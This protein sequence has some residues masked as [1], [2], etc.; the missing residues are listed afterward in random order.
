M[1][2]G[3]IDAL[4]ASADG[5]G[6]HAAKTP[7][8][9]LGASDLRKAYGIQ[10]ASY[11]MGAGNTIAIIDLEDDPKAE[12]DMNAYR[13]QFG[14]PSCTSSSGCFTKVEENNGVGISNLKTTSDASET[15]ADLDMVSAACPA[16][17]IVLVE[18]P[19]A[20]NSASDARQLV[21]AFNYA[22]T[23]S[24]LAISSSVFASEF[25]GEVAFDAQLPGGVPI[26]EA[27]GDFPKL[28]YWPS[29]S[30]NQNVITV[31]GTALSASRGGVATSSTWSSTSAGCSK[32]EPSTSWLSI[33]QCHGKRAFSDVSA[34]AQNIAIYDT[35]RTKS[36]AN[37]FAAAG[38]S[39]AAPLIAGITGLTG[40]QPSASD[41]AANASKL[42]D[43]TTGSNA[44]RCSTL[45]CK[46]V[47]GWDAPTG[48]G[49]PVGLT[50]LL[51]GG[52]IADG[53]IA[54]GVNVDG[55]LTIG[56]SWASSEDV[57]NGTSLGLRYLPTNGD[58]ISPG[59]ACEGWG[60]ADGTTGIDGYADQATGDLNLNLDSFT[61]SA[62]SAT[63]VT[64]ISGAIRVTNA[65]G[66]TSA[67]SNAIVDR[68]TITNLQSDPIGDLLYERVAD[69]DME[70][71]AYNELVT[72]SGLGSSPSLVGLT[73]DG[74]QAPDPLASLTDLGA[75]SN[76]AQYGPL[77]QGVAVRFDFGSLDPGKSVTFNVYYGAASNEASA[78]KALTAVGAQV[79][80]LGEPSSSSDGSP[81]TAFLGFSGVGGAVMPQ[82]TTSSVRRFPS[83][84]Q[85]EQ[86]QL[87][88]RLR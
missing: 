44:S 45:L 35:W 46:A 58:F 56:E 16:C 5:L 59:C 32:Y 2:L 57:E 52:A 8:G 86:A 49:T 80:S 75:T 48:W 61:A 36:G 78:L 47:R 27:A 19:N 1:H 69:W 4:E 60:V 79:Y 73:N 85:R 30:P 81:N 34:V 10:A 3:I 6:P 62:T 18:F 87:F 70:P 28:T 83:M 39:L 41:L 50:S 42:T 38:T 53:N 11:A 63:A 20:N 29:V 88:Q 72:L 65:Y 24:P 77:D 37:W 67:T 15:S 82:V 7:S 74:F 68:V 40:V 71:T 22:E 66:P 26:F 14:L 25:A 54:L 13:S 55:S 17:R 76:V 23:F 9:M 84:S 51:P 31:G 43:V 33:A 21:D 64:D 12:S